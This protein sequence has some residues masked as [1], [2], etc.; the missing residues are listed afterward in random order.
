MKVADVTRS[1][2]GKADGD[3]PKDDS[4]QKVQQR[5]QQRPQQRRRQNHG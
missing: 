4:A 3:G 1:R 5:L 2:A